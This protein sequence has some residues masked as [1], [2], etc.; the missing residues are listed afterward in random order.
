MSIEQIK[1]Y[2]G[3]KNISEEEATQVFL[4]VLVLKH[5]SL[6]G[7]HFMGGTALVLGYGNPRFSED[8]DLTQV[9]NPL[10]LSQ[11]LINA[12]REASQWLGTRVAVQKPKKGKRTWKMI[13][14]FNPS[15]KRLPTSKIWMFTLPRRESNCLSWRKRS[16]LL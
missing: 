5:L 8:I 7:A 1:T 11:G 9:K 14:T 13:C 12:A 16:L 2:A 3:E 10:K 6:P 15:L 4:Q